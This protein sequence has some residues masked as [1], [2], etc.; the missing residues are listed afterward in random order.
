MVIRASA[1]CRHYKRGRHTIKAVDNINLTLHRGELTAIVGASGSGKSTL[2]NLL[3][4]LDTPTSGSI[5]FGDLSLTTISRRE[6]AHVRAQRVGMIFQSFNLMQHMSAL[7]NVELGL[8]F[9]EVGRRERRRRASHILERLG[10]GDRLDHSPQELSGGEQQRVAI[11]RALVKK[12]EVLFADEPTGNLDQDNSRQ[13]GQLLEEFNREGLSLVMVTHNQDL[14][15]IHG[16]RILYMQYGSL[17]DEISP[18]H[19]QE[20]P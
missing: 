11:A 5:Q 16:R 13:I 1:L 19:G 12:P 4:G 3:A 6:K 18:N 10:M 20:R 2:L 14:A 7:Q 17:A 9:S 15:R 8:Y